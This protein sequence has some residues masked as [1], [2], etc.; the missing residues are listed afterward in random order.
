MKWLEGSAYLTE[1]NYCITLTQIDIE[2]GLIIGNPEVGE[3]GAWLYEDGTPMTQL[4]KI[5]GKI[6]EMKRPGKG[7]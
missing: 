2:A 4:A 7:M 5:Y 6:M 1:N 3:S